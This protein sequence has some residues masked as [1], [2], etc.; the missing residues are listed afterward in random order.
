MA[1]LARDS[2]AGTPGTALTARP[3]EV[4]TRDWEYEVGTANLVVGGG[5][6]RCEA[7]TE[8]M[9]TIAAPTTP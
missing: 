5:R 4:G 3:S 1:T 8:R 7:T 2:F 6:L 9:A